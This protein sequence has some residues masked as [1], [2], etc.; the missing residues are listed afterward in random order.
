MNEWINIQCCIRFLLKRMNIRSIFNAQIELNLLVKSRMLRETSS[1]YLCTSINPF[2]TRLTKIIIA[3][4][5]L[6]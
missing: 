6:L 4:G 1:Q 3:H 2:M 5:L